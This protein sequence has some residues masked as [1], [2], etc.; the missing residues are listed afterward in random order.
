MWG[1]VGPPITLC[2]DSFLIDS[3]RLGY[4][5]TMFLSPPNARTK[6]IRKMVESAFA[7][8]G[9]K[10]NTFEIEQREISLFL[11]NLLETSGDFRRHIR[12]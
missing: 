9:L 4:E 1:D 3:Y 6:E 2:I 8:K 11:Q 5:E 10:E 7:P 12:L